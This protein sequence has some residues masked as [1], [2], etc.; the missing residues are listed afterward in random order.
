MRSRNL[1]ML[2]MGLV[3]PIL[4]VDAAQAYYTPGLGRFINRDPY[5]ELGSLIS[6]EAAA[7]QSYVAEL[8]LGVAWGEHSL[9]WKRR[10]VVSNNRYEF[11][12]NNPLS[13]IDPDGL[14]AQESQPTTQPEPPRPSG[15]AGDPKE[16]V[17]C[18]ANITKFSITCK[19]GGDSVTCGTVCPDE[20]DYKKYGGPTP[21][22]EY[23]IDT[24]YWHKDNQCDWY[25]LCPMKDDKSGYHKY[26]D[27]DKYGR[28]TMGLHPG[29]VSLGCITVKKDCWEKLK[30]LI[31]KGELKY[32][33]QKFK[34]TVIVQ[35]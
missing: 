6:R 3:A 5:H 33:N 22:N 21:P 10:V 23:L 8:Q 2:V 29:T 30:A 16:G 20:K 26:R 32:K 13:W 17:V 4:L 35:E 1:L 28:T 25:N 18:W 14:A 12:L 24:L 11:A 31:E 9:V 15:P 7:G 34:G 27:K 19:L